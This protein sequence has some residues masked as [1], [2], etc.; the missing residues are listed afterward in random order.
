MT[1][2]QSTAAEAGAPSCKSFVDTLV[3]LGTSWA[4]Y[5]LKIGKQALVTSAETLGKTADTLET[6]A[7]AIE[8]KGAEMKDAAASADAAPSAPPAPPAPPSDSASAPT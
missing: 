3:G 8:K 4:A 5:G 1:T 6:L 7:V 2:T